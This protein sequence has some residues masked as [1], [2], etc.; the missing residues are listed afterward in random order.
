MFFEVGL[1]IGCGPLRQVAR[2]IAKEEAPEETVMAFTGAG[3]SA[4]SGVPT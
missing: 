2:W 3:I 4:A 1:G